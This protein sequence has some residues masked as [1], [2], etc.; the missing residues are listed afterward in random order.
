MLRRPPWSPT[1]PLPPPWKFPFDARISH[2]AQKSI[3]GFMAQPA[4][5]PKDNI[6]PVTLKL[7][8]K[9]YL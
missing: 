8:S 2:L 4:F 3:E 5:M 1:M 7:N 6:I 9:I